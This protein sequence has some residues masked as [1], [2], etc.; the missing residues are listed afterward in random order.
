MFQKGERP[1]LSEGMFLKDKDEALKLI[2][3]E[4]DRLDALTGVDTSCIEIKISGRLKRR[5]GY[6]SI[7]RKNIFSKVR[8][9]IVIA[10]MTFRSSE[11]FYDVIRHEYAHAVCYLRDPRHRHN[12]DRVWKAV[13]KEVGCTPRATFK[14]AED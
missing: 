9:S 4:Y 5:Y 12:H 13:C 8:L 2:R 1:V 10:T 3:A 14:A 7:Y 11:L 6:F